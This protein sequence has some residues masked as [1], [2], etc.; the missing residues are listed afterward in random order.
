MSNLTSKDFDPYFSTFP[1]CSFT[2]KMSFFGETSWNNAFLL[3]NYLFK[4]VK[5]CHSRQTWL[6]KTG[7][8]SI[9]YSFLEIRQPQK[10]TKATSNHINAA[11]VILLSVCFLF[12]LPNP[13]S[14]DFTWSVKKSFRRLQIIFM[15]VNHTYLLVTSSVNR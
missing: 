10:R 9:G 8:S 2:F 4:I 7:F 13:W 1:P 14:S 12:Y 5:S 15:L 3:L 11:S 6:I